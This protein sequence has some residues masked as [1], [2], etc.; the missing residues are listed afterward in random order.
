MFCLSERTHS[1]PFTAHRKSPFGLDSYTEIKTQTD[2]KTFNQT[3]I[4]AEEKKNLIMTGF[5]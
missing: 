2:T 4:L 5:V 3:E 1:N